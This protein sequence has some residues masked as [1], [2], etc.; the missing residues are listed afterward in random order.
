LASCQQLGQ[1]GAKQFFK[2]KYLLIKNKIK[3]QITVVPGAGAGFQHLECLFCGK[4]SPLSG[5]A[6][7]NS[8]CGLSVATLAERPIGGRLPMLTT[9]K[10]VARRTKWPA[11]QS[12]FGLLSKVPR[13][14]AT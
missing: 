13:L 1:P 3:P 7:R 5:E 4:Y 2:A 6:L 12:K 14:G 11:E 8:G 10:P 9:P